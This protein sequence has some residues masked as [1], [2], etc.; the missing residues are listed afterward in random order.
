MDANIM[1][2]IQSY[3]L[4]RWQSLALA[5]AL[6]IPFHWYANAHVLPQTFRAAVPTVVV[7]TQAGTPT[8]ESSVKVGDLTII[9]PWTRQPPDGARV[10]GGYMRIT[11]T[12]TT[13]DRL[14]GGR[15][16]FAKRVEVHEMAM[17]NGVMRM[18]ELDKG[19]EIKPGET[20]ELKP[21]GVHIM[22]MDMTSAPTAGTPA[23]VTLVFEKAGAVEVELAVTPA[24][25]TKPAGGH[26]HH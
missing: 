9:G 5:L 23:K 6:T 17:A 26:T 22:F 13:A 11:N 25:A 18:R 8:A 10:A 3:G 4:C 2:P 21:G 16:A 19:L 15:S 20:V 7:Q 14:V 24:G 12:G 1:D